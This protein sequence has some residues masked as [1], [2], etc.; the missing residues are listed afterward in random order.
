M[1][2]EGRMKNKKKIDKAKLAKIGLGLSVLLVFAI[3][4]G[5]TFKGR[6]S[7]AD[8]EDYL[9]DNLKVTKVTSTSAM[10]SWDECKDCKG[11][12]VYKKASDGTYNKVKKTTSI[13]YT[14][15]SLEPGQFAGTYTVVKYM[16]KNSDADIISVANHRK[17]VNVLTRPE[18]VTGLVCINKDELDAM[19]ENK[20]IELQWNSAKGADFYNIYIKKENEK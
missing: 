9:V 1:S 10:L 13:S 5:I 20:Y 7:K 17:V 16:D 15:E 11:Y 12:G 19:N 4:V 3:I 8:K 14:I 18:G 2:N 6:T